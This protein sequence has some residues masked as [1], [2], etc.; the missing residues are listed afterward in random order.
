VLKLNNIVYPVKFNFDTGTT[1]TSVPLSEKRVTNLQPNNVKS[2]TADGN[3]LVSKEKGTLNLDLISREGNEVKLPINN[4]NIMPVNEV[5]IS[6]KDVIK[7]ARVVLAN[8][9]NG[10]SYLQLYGSKDKVALT[11]DR[12][13]FWIQHHDKHAGKAERAIMKAS[14]LTSNTTEGPTRST[15][16]REKPAGFWSAPKRAYTKKSSRADDKGPATEQR[17]DEITDAKAEKRHDN[18]PTE[19]RGDE[20]SSRA[21]DKGPATEQKGDEITD[22]KAEKRAK[23]AQRQAAAEARQREFERLEGELNAEIIASQEENSTRTEEHGVMTDQVRREQAD[24]MLEEKSRVLDGQPARTTSFTDAE[25]AVVKIWKYFVMVHRRWNH[26]NFKELALLLWKL[27]D[28]TPYIRLFCTRKEVELWEVPLLKPSKKY[29]YHWLTICQDCA[30]TSHQQVRARGNDPHSMAKG[31]RDMLY[32]DFIPIIKP[33][34]VD[35]F[36]A[37]LL[38]KDKFT[39]LV[40]SIPIK[41]PST[42]EA[43]LALRNFFIRHGGVPAFRGTRLRSDNASC[44]DVETND[45][46]KKFCDIME[47]ESKNSP[48]YRQDMNGEVESF[49]KTH[50]RKERAIMKH[51]KV[52]TKYWNFAS[53]FQ[54]DASNSSPLTASASRYSNDLNK[55]HSPYQR[56]HGRARDVDHIKVFGC[57]AMVPLRV[58][59]KDKEVSSKFK[60]RKIKC[61]YLG[62]ARNASYGT[63]VFGYIKEGSTTENLTFR[64]AHY[65]DVDWIEDEMYFKD[66]G[67]KSNHNLPAE[68]D[69][70]PTRVN[71]LSAAGEIDFIHM[72]AK[73]TTMEDWGPDHADTT[74][75]AMMLTI[76]LL[77]QCEEES[78]ASSSGVQDMSWKKYKTESAEVQGRWSGPMRKEWQGFRDRAAYQEV[79]VE[80]LPKKVLVTGIKSIFE[81]KKSGEFKVRSVANWFEPLAKAIY[82]DALP[83]AFSPASKQENLR[84]LL[85]VESFLRKSGD[86]D[87]HDPVVR[88]AIDIKQAY[89]NG[90][91]EEDSIKYYVK[92]PDGFYEFMDGAPK[93]GIVWLLLR[94]LYG[95]PISGRLWY[96]KFKKMIEMSGFR[97]L[98]KEACVFAKKDSTGKLLAVMNIHVD[99]SYMIGKQ[100]VLDQ[101]TEDVKKMVSVS[102]LGDTNKH[103]GMEITIDPD[104]DVAISQFKMTM[105]LLRTHGLVRLAK[106]GE[107]E[108]V[109]NRQPR[110]LPMPAGTKIEKSDTG[111]PNIS[112]DDLVG[113]LLW[114][115]RTCNPGLGVY[116]SLLGSQ[117]R[118]PTE[119]HYKLAQRVMSWMMGYPHAGLRFKA[120]TTRP[121]LEVYVDA[122]LGGQD[123]EGKKLRSRG[124]YVIYMWGQVVHFSSRK[125]AITSTSTFDA[126]LRTI[127]EVL[128]KATVMKANLV[129]LGLMKEEDPILVRSDSET[130]VK[131]LNNP[132]GTQ[133]AGHLEFED[134][135]EFDLQEYLVRYPGQTIKLQEKL[136][137]SRVVELVEQKRIKV[138]HVAGVSNI[139][140][141]LTK[142]L[143]PEKFYWC[144]I[145][146][147]CLDVTKAGP[148]KGGVCD[149][150]TLP[151]FK[152]LRNCSDNSANE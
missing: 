63:C 14:K 70:A 138:V 94:P 30:A 97:R 58:L 68:V 65:T 18:G 139:A 39:K 147:M 132:L 4:V 7:Q 12:S 71:R 46:W 98:D 88:R 47:I 38:I 131:T 151:K 64:E 75:A 20:K 29:T 13:G 5:L 112:L 3:I 21:D 62:P 122:E 26:C 84:M 130:A 123:K 100:S 23:K 87:P 103:L 74:E 81:I 72:S 6:G 57:S 73:L 66:Q 2:R 101:F 126:E 110:Y 43:I 17:G 8:Q 99:D 28:R 121:P 129:E 108:P 55:Y 50:Y 42:S 114:I 127:M 143:G 61:C 44:F 41:A 144:I 145:R 96:I 67:Y 135:R 86:G 90:E 124:G 54:V 140:D 117:V 148:H 152:N 24:A 40:D 113:S 83:D 9:E 78:Q 118:N 36:T 33:A 45:E 146:S 53:N 27:G 1:S 52:P 10:G 111:D 133:K 60:D 92:P 82:R 31:P 141:Y 149:C 105:E 91:F 106:G 34:S 56:F 95:L 150:V 116:T 22:A 35:G 51:S 120:D 19:Q 128:E 125:H 109:K 77:E 134:V 89:L 49:A 85:A 119:T 136:I 69:D 142:C 15:R 79:R 16:A 137:L 25:L 104:G 11:E 59:Q 37:K 80:D 115:M 93:P 32:I 76:N 48:S 102:E 107:Y